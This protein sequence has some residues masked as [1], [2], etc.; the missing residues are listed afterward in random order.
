[1][2]KRILV[3]FS[4]LA[5]LLLGIQAADRIAAGSIRAEANEPL[6]E[7]F[8]TAYV[9]PEVKEEGPP[10]TPPLG[11]SEA[12]GDSIWGFDCQSPPDDNQCRGVEFDGHY[13]YVTGGGGTNH[14]DPNKLHFFDR[15]GNYIGSVDQPTTSYWGWRDIAY[16]GNHMYS[17]EGRAIDEWYV[18]GLPD[19]PVLHVVG[20]F[21][22]PEDPNFAMAYDPAT[23]HFWTANY[24]G[25]YIY[26]I[27]RS[28][29]VINQ[30][31]STYSIYGMTW[32]TICPD[33]PWLWVSAQGPSVVHQFDPTTGTYTGVSFPVSGIAG[34]CAFSED[35]HPDYGIFFYGSQWY[36]DH[37]IAYE[38]CL[39]PA[40]S[41]G[42]V[43]GGGWVPGEPHDP[44]SKRTFG[45]NVH[46]EAGAVW[47]RL[48]FND[49]ETKMRVHSDTMK[50]LVIHGDT[51]ANF[52]GDC[53][54]DGMSGY[55]F[56][57]EVEDRGEPG[58]GVDRFSMNVSGPGGF[59][60]SADDFLGGGNIQIHT[61]TDSDFAGG[62]FESEREPGY[63]PNP[64]LKM[65]EKTQ[66]LA[67]GHGLSQSSPNPF[68][69]FTIINYQLPKPLH[70]TLTIYDLSGKLVRTLVDKPR[71]MG[72]YAVRWNGRDE[73]GRAVS[74]GAYFYRL[75]AAGLTSTK[76]MVV[77][78]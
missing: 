51:V 37:V 33:G 56:E 38:M 26:E 12:L 19:S 44:G 23:D 68:A 20:S 1:M 43:T 49:H 40:P 66:Q 28:G 54:V 7:E 58:H 27:D 45:F 78:R 48:Q 9:A 52:S 25:S 53:R 50:T 70:T 32:D 59:S 42:F 3:L 62:E 64:L 16:D 57:C 76:K 18:T 61:P 67:I 65:D 46:S 22:G 35:W 4:V 21:P 17:S 63:Y 24:Y 47:G 55:S 60:Y 41:L 31:P 2:S 29:A 36:P 77:V 74:S 11:Q 10:A 14:P 39:K 30:Y 13:F 69:K 75:Q 72:Y 6:T 71:D 8:R 73:M 5:L 34:G 15:D